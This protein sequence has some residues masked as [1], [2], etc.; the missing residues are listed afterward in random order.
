MV[1]ALFYVDGGRCVVMVSVVLVDPVVDG[2]NR[3]EGVVMVVVRSVR[4]MAFRDA[5]F[6][7]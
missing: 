3:V 5:L 2:F 4:G 6:G 7:N 1:L